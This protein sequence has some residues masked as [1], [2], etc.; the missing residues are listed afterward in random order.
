LWS[1]I[2]IACSKCAEAVLWLVGFA[3]VWGKKDGLHC[4]VDKCMPDELLPFAKTKLS[5]MSWQRRRRLYQELQGAA[6]SSHCTLD[7]LVLI[8][9]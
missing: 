4:L 6:F 9:A 7:P 2:V 5:M 3:A 8:D 1:G